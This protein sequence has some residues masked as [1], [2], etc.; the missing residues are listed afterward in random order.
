MSRR[1]SH[2]IPNLWANSIDSAWEREISSVIAL[3]RELS[4]RWTAAREGT[5]AA[6]VA[7]KKE[8]RFMIHLES[9]D[10][11]TLEN[12]ARSRS[13]NSA[14]LVLRRLSRGAPPPFR[15]AQQAEASGGHHPRCGLRN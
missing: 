11:T 9:I 3:T 2:C 8:R 13:P 15:H 7:A 4:M 14:P 12:P 6:S 1:E 5:A 10:C